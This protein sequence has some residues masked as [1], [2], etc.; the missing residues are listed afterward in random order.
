M[1][2]VSKLFSEEIEN[3]LVRTIVSGSTVPIYMNPAEKYRINALDSL[4]WYKISIVKSFEE[5]FFAKNSWRR[6]FPDEYHVCSRI[7]I[8]WFIFTTV[9]LC[10]QIQRD[11][12][13][14]SRIYTYSLDPKIERNFDRKFMDE[15]IEQVQ[16]QIEDAMRNE[17]FQLVNYLI[18]YFYRLFSCLA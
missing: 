1:L 11:V 9:F 5:P 10:T 2:E 17:R 12:E 7:N 3:V 16:S 15:T 14:L 4:L 18:A 13:R 8:F 6:Y